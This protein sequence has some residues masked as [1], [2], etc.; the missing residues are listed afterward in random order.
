MVSILS[1]QRI[2]CFVHVTYRDMLLDLFFRDVC[3]CV[4]MWLTCHGT[5]ETS[6]PPL[7]SNNVAAPQ[8][9]SGLQVL[10]PEL[11]VKAK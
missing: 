6:C 2:G 9:E 7:C 5:A 1:T 11:V 4:W 10:I 3:V 8:A